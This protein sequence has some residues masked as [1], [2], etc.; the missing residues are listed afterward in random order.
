ME[1]NEAGPAWQ[2]VMALSIAFLALEG[3]GLREK[4]LAA[5]GLVLERLGLSRKAAADLIGTSS[6]SLSELLRLARNK[7]GG[8]RG[9]A[10]GK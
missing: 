4:D 1:E 9:K 6:A 7:K 2:E 5:Q 3:S 8:S 10:N